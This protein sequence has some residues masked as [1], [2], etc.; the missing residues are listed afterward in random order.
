MSNHCP[1]LD[2]NQHEP[3]LTSPSSWRVCQIPPPGHFIKL[4]IIESF[5]SIAN[6]EGKPEYRAVE[7]KRQNIKVRSYVILRKI[8]KIRSLTYC[9]KAHDIL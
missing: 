2:S 6:L 4:L 9:A 1:R 7:K 8:K 5:L 3:K